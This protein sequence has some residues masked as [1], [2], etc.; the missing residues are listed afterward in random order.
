MNS[1]DIPMKTTRVGMPQPCAGGIKFT[2]VVERLPL[3]IVLESR[4]SQM[5]TRKRTKIPSI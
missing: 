2:E 1:R 4:L 3:A 5:N